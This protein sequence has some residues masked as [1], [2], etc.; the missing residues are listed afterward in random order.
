MPGETAV[1]Y[2]AH[3]RAVALVAYAGGDVELLRAERVADQA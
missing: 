2:D 1:G 3:G